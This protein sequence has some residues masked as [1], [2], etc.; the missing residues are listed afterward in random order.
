MATDLS[1]A[2]LPNAMAA[3]QAAT[4]A[5]L[6]L[7]TVANLWEWAD[8]ELRRLARTFALFVERAD[9][10]AAGAGQFVYALPAGHLATLQLE[11]NGRVLRPAN[12]HELESG[13][14]GWEDASSFPPT[15]YVP[16]WQGADNVRLYPIPNK[17]GTWAVLYELEPPSVSAAQP[18]APLAAPVADIVALRVIAEARRRE[19]DSQMPEAVSAC[20][21]LIGMYEA[22]MRAYYGGG[23]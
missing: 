13:D 23:L 11:F 5:D 12:V 4:A 6:D 8:E 10:Q 22:V 19:G 15:R 16:D 21:Q 14:A 17:A 18:S 2:V 3:L 1:L 20:E 7:C 9:G